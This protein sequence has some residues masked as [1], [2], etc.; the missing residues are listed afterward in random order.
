[1]D[2]QAWYAQGHG[3]PAAAAAAAAAAQIHQSGGF[4]VSMVD[5]AAHAQDAG[6]LTQEEKNKGMASVF[7]RF[8]KEEEEAR[9]KEARKIDGKQLGEEY[10]TEVVESEDEEEEGEGA[11]AR[12][13]KDAES[14]S[15]SCTLCIAQ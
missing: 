8:T 1:M 6:I 14:S 7:R 2:A 5:V 15:P 4:A 12:V 9:R 3:D 13:R 10:A 11:I